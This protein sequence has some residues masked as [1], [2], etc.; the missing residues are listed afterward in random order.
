MRTPEQAVFDGV[1]RP[2]FRILFL[3]II[4]YIVGIFHEVPWRMLD[5][6]NLLDNYNF[7]W[8]N[9]DS[10]WLDLQVYP[11]IASPFHSS[12]LLAFPLSIICIVCSIFDRW[13]ISHTTAL[14]AAVTFAMYFC[15]RV[16]LIHS[17]AAEV[18]FFAITSGVLFG[19]YSVV[20]TYVI[21]YRP[22]CKHV[23]KN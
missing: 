2:W 1:S 18:I 9:R 4:A 11:F 10:G 13:N 16:H 19:L 12:G 17:W 5:Q 20:Y 15:S 22:R 6:L 14:G 3:F 21:Y 7:S 8:R 23:S